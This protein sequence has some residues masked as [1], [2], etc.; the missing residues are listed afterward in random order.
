MLVSNK[1]V[2]L[3]DSE[4]VSFNFMVNVFHRNKYDSTVVV[5]YTD[6][7]IGK[8]KNLNPM[9]YTVVGGNLNVEFRHCHVGTNSLDFNLVA[10]LGGLV[11]SMKRGTIYIVSNDRGYDTILHEFANNRVEVKRLS[12]IH[13][14]LEL[15]NDRELYNASDN[16]TGM[17]TSDFDDESHKYML[18]CIKMIEKDLYEIVNNRA[19]AKNLSAWLY[20]NI[21]QRNLKLNCAEIKHIYVTSLK[22]RFTQ[23]K[24][25]SDISRIKSLYSMYIYTGKFT[26]DGVSSVEHRRY[27]SGLVSSEKSGIIK[28]LTKFRLSQEISE[29]LADLIFSSAET[30]CMPSKNDL[31]NTL[32]LADAK[33]YTQGKARKLVNRIY[34][35]VRSLYQAAYYSDVLTWQREDIEVNYSEDVEVKEEIKVA[36]EEVLDETTKIILNFID[37]LSLPDSYDYSDLVDDLTGLIEKDGQSI[38]DNLFNY[39][40]IKGVKRDDVISSLLNFLWGAYNN[41]NIEAVFCKK[42]S[43]LCKYC[44]RYSRDINSRKLCDRIR[45]VVCDDPLAVE[46]FYK[47]VKSKFVDDISLHEGKELKLEDWRE[48]LIFIEV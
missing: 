14:L 24:F 29:G 5:F 36:E 6:T 35:A 16:I 22:K 43:N 41:K 4:N 40:Y 28:Q 1:E 31:C 34:S 21:E 39:R 33:V 25:D 30:G 32:V 3:I 12:E 15:N 27:V 18:D 46:V 20:D 17:G 37:S 47:L 26:K 38:W 48:E 13:G 42:I 45:N 23:S 44:K 2:F 10:Y 8:I 11:E 19:I 9:S 7:S